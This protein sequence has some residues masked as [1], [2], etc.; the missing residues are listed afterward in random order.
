MRPVDFQQHSQKNQRAI[1]VSCPETNLQNRTAG[2]S[3]F[4]IKSSIQIYFII[5]QPRIQQQAGI[6][7]LLANLNF[8][9]L[10][11]GAWMDIWLQ[12]PP[13][14]PPRRALVEHAIVT[15]WGPFV[16]K[17]S[18]AEEALAVRDA[19]RLEQHRTP[20]AEWVR[21]MAHPSGWQLLVLNPHRSLGRKR[22]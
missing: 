11:T 3:F 4:S 10:E 9:C 20:P 7:D 21:A 16:P 1:S 15:R 8:C 14:P 5:S 6:Q 22:P 13:P 17:L 18:D 19:R 12:R 2:E